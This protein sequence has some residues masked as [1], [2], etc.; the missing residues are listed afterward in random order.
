MGL[1][2]NRESKRPEN[3]KPAAQQREELNER[4]R[5]EEKL[6]QRFEVGIKSL[7]PVFTEA[8]GLGIAG[9]SFG[10]MTIPK[11]LV[12]DLTGMVVAIARTKNAQ[13]LSKEGRTAASK[14]HG[15]LRRV[16]PT[17]LQLA[18]SLDKYELLCNNMLTDREAPTFRIDDPLSG[19]GILTIMRVYDTNFGTSHAYRVADLFLALTLA[20]E[21]TPELTGSRILAAYRSALEAFVAEISKSSG[22]DP[23]L[24]VPAEAFPRMTE[25]YE[26]LGV[27]SDCTDEELKE[28]YHR[29]V[30]YWHPDK[31]NAV[32]IPK[33]MKDLATRKLARVNEAY[34]RVK[35]ERQAAQPIGS[36]K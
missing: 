4:Q 28:A 20:L 31:F 19:F 2:S 9:D 34:D 10:G 26:A 32:Q 36:E 14:A 15:I 24:G 25:A 12:S 6:I 7:G 3:L 18:V 22:T 17:Q 21:A 5:E 35:K 16:A 27:H 29:K 8:I 23:F 33:E 13:Y 11:M 1:F 30:N